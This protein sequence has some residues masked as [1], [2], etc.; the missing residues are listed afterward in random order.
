MDDLRELVA[1]MAANRKWP[2]PM[3]FRPEIQP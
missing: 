2:S 3:S 1:N